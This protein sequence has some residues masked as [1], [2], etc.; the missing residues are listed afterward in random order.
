MPRNLLL[1][2]MVS[3]ILSP[4]SSVD[5]IVN[6]G[7]DN[8]CMLKDLER[9]TMLDEH[10]KGCDGIALQWDKL[11][12]KH[13]DEITKW[14]A[15]GNLTGMSLRG[16]DL[17]DADATRLMQAVAASTSLISFSYRDNAL[18][19]SGGHAVAKLAANGHLEV[20][21]MRSIPIGTEEGSIVA[22][23]KAL[24]HN[25]HLKA[26]D[27]SVCDI[28]TQ[29]VMAL[30]KALGEN[31]VLERLDLRHNPVGDEGAIALAKAIETL[32][33]DSSLNEVL[34]D[35]PSIGN[36]GMRALKKAAKQV[37]RVDVWKL[38]HH[39]YTEMRYSWANEVIKDEEAK[40][41]EKEKD[42]V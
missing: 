26:L 35:H 42:E 1:A 34:I 2:T 31:R 25:T 30:A 36:A 4:A 12:D 18:G 27:M 6:R 41:D 23:A 8:F 3:L 19:Q 11:E 28:D 29:G 39:K 21:S 32:P 20:L 16:N 13:V 38:W 10:G 33:D 7:V 5:T 17:S 40:G 22:L 9:G 24:R 15:A 14:A 37:P